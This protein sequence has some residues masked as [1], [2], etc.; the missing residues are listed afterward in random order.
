LLYF[1]CIE[2]PRNALAVWSGVA[3]LL[4]N[5]ISIMWALP[6]LGKSS[7]LGLLS[8]L[9]S[10][11]TILGAAMLIHP[12]SPAGTD[13]LIV[14]CAQLIVVLIS[15]SILGETPI[16][17]LCQKSVI[18][19][20]IDLKK[21]KVFIQTSLAIQ[22]YLS[23][24]VILVGQLLGQTEAGIYKSALIASWAANTVFGTVQL[25]LFPKLVEWNALPK[26][27]R[28]DHKTQVF[29]ML[30][31]VVGS[32]IL[33]IALAMPILYE[34][35][36]GPEYAEAWMYATMLVI[37]RGISSVHAPH[38]LAL[39]AEGTESTLFKIVASVA[40]LNLTLNWTLI[41]ILGLWAPAGLSI[42][43]EL[44]ILIATLKISNNPPPNQNQK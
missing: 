26:L 7:M 16:I 12:G 4:A 30:V 9:Q 28:I 41:P 24:D 27:E 18:Q 3:L 39:L 29:R 14:S 6:A 20:L 10:A 11:L 33:V 21:G 32:A 1:I 31:I 35:I 23:I 36:F 40:I 43:N 15:L 42:V 2:K 34:K 13:L 44:I 37:A 38:S 19:S 17:N 8:I 22:F 25:T 5:A